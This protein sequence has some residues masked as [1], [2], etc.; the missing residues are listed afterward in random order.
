MRGTQTARAETDP[1]AHPYR[2]V[3]RPEHEHACADEILDGPDWHADPDW[4]ALDHANPD[5][6]SNADRDSVAHRQ[7]D[8]YGYPDE[9]GDA[10]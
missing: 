3:A 10:N 1:L 8:E 5:R 4:L 9:D 6:R 7:P 2:A